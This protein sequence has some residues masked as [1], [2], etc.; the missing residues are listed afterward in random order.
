MEAFAA[1]NPYYACQYDNDRQGNHILAYQCTSPQAIPSAFD[2]VTGAPTAYSSGIVSAPRGAGRQVDLDRQASKIVKA[3]NGLGADVV[4]LEELENPNKL[5]KGVTNGPLNPDPN[6]ADS[7]FG[8]PI[9]WRDET[10]NYLV[11]KLN[12]DAGGDIWSFVASPEESTDATRVNHM[13]ATMQ[14][15]GAPVLP[16]QTNGTCSWA[17]GQDV[18]RS[19]F[20]YK[21]A[22]VVP[23]GPSDID[24]PNSSAGVPSPF[25]NAREPL[26]QFFKPVGHP[27][28]DGFA[29]I[30]NHFKSKGDSDPSATGGN[31][32]TAN[33][34]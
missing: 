24:F 25:D 31:A 34:G 12:I 15:N 30:V 16:P 8:T 11:G 29:V 6:K 33:G 5:R 14:P 28:S 21:K 2:P 26:A 32:S 20:L 3:I 17:S 10:I 23:V 13:C 7:G 19:G 27:N 22:M 9:P 18:I 4:S 1:D